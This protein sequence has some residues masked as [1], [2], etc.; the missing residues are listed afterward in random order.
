M[1]P[2]L[3]LKCIDEDN[4]SYYNSRVNHE[5]DS[6][7]DLYITHDVVFQPGETIIV[8]LKV[9][10]RMVNNDGNTIPYYLYPRS[11]ISKTP[12]R[13]ANSVGIIDKDY[14]GNIKVALTH[15]PTNNLI[16]SLLQ[17]ST[18]TV[19]IEDFNYT[20]KKGT[21]VV[22]ICSATLDPIKLKLVESLDETERG[23][24]GFGSTGQ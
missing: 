7:V 11:S 4:K 9:Q 14:R 2:T 17:K 12:L 21:R 20:L 24:G 1:T 23:D 19:K 22:Q 10:S 15:I 16:N 8:D 13:M 6:G 5:S 3:E 18:E